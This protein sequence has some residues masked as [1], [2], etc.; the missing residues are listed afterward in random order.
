MKCVTEEKVHACCRGTVCVCING[1]QHGET[2]KLSVCWEGGDLRSLWVE[3][4]GVEKN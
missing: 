4:H 3:D 1:T 2:S